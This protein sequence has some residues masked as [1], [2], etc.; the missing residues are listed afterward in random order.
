MLASV[1]PLVSP[2]LT[3]AVTLGTFAGWGLIGVVVATLVK[4]RLPT[5]VWRAV[6]AGSFGA[7]LLA[8][9]HSV[10]AGTDTVTAEVRLMYAGTGTVLLAVVLHRLALASLNRVETRRAG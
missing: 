5:W 7:F 6:H 2:R 8:L 1:V 10:L 4:A 3:A 9:M